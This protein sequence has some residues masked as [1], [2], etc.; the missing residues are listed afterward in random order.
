LTSI[1]KAATEMMDND[2][3]KSEVLY[4]TKLGRA[5]IIPTVEQ[6]IFQGGMKWSDL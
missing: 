3:L 2:D 4:V 5:R 1:C 6:K